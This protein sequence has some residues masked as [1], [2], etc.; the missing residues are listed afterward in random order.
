MTEDIQEVWSSV[1]AVPY[2]RSVYSEGESDY[3]SYEKKVVLT[4][5]EIREKLMKA[6]PDIVF[7]GPVSEDVEVVQYTNSQRA[8]E[9]RVGSITIPERS[10][11]NC[12]RWHPR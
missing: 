2:L 7:L 10:S 12:F 9:I 1:G 11:G 5:E 8:K 4:G 6:Y 3:S